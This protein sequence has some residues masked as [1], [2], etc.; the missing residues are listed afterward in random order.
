MFGIMVF[1]WC[2]GIAKFSVKS[3]Q[4][5]KQIFVWVFILSCAYGIGMEYVQENLVVHRSFDVGDIIADIVGALCGLGYAW[6]RF[7]KK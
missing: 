3:K 1:L 5:L 6:Y 2:W 7:I 4:K